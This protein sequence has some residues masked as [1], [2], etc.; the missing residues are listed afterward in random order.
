MMM[1]M[2]IMMMMKNSYK[3]TR[4]F[5]FRLIL[6][7]IYMNIRNF[8]QNQPEDVIKVFLKLFVESKYCIDYSEMKLMCNHNVFF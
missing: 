6:Y 7:L 1:M 3:R 4:D 2:M 8:L 5:L